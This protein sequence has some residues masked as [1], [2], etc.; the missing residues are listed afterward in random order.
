MKR[1]M[2]VMLAV[3]CVLA[4]TGFSGGADQADVFVRQ[5]APT[6]KVLRVG[7]TI[8]YPPFAYYQ[9]AT[10]TYIGFDIE[11]MQDL[12]SEMGYDKVE[13]VQMGFND[14][15]PSLQEGKVDAV[16]S[17]MTVTDER[18]EAADFTA[19]YLEGVKS[20]VV[21]PSGAEACSAD[22][23]NKKRIAVEAGSVHANRVKQYSNAVIEC[24]SAEE[25]LKLV[26]DQKADF[27]VMDN[28]TAR[29]YITNFYRDKLNLMAELPGDTETGVGIAA[30]KGNQEM[31]DKLN[32]ALQN[33]RGNAAYHQTKRYYFG[34]LEV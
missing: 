18:R 28:Y 20:G 12:G 9:E 19:P 17:C 7:T 8:D 31:L 4:I 33:Y 23:M 15:L 29:F 13:F 3:I 1:I 24:G 30:A 2:S 10:Q 6:E 14:L 16:I 26:L 5:E 11:L 34:R 22:A 25:A 21:A 27:A 32:A